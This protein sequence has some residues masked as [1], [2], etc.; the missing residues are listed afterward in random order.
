MTQLNA[1][2]GYSSIAKY[3]RP[4]PEIDED[5]WQIAESWL[6]KE[7]GP[8]MRDSAILPY[9]IVLAHIDKTTS[10]GYP[11]NRAHSTKS[12]V[13]KN[14]PF[15]QEEVQLLFDKLATDSPIYSFWTCAQK[16]ELRVKSKLA[17]DPPRHRTF[18]ASSLDFTINSNRMCLDQNNKFYRANTKTA[19]F[20]GGSKFRKG[21]DSAYRK[22][23][24]HPNGFA[25]D[26][27]DYDACVHRRALWS[28]A[29]FR[30][31]ML[32]VEDRTP[33]NWIRMKNVYQ[34]IINSM[35]VLEDGTVVFK[36]TG[37]PS[38]SANTVVD[39]TL[40]LY[41]DLAYAWV[42][43][44][45]KNVDLRRTWELEHKEDLTEAE[46]DELNAS[47]KTVLSYSHFKSNVELLLY[48]D[49]NTF[50]VS[51]DCIS[52]FNA[53]NIIEVW[54]TIGI[55]TKTDCLD[56]R[57][58][59]EL[60]FLSQRVLKFK[61]T[62][63]PYPDPDS[64]INSLYHKTNSDDNRWHLLRAFALRNECWAHKPTRQL[65]QGYIDW[66]WQTRGETLNGILSILGTNAKVT[67]ENI[68]SV[69]MTD[70]EL[71]RLYMGYEVR[72]GNSTDGPQ[73]VSCPPCPFHDQDAT[74]PLPCAQSLFSCPPVSFC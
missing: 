16:H 17:E 35:I 66:M 24:R 20:V 40:V 43:L 32:R 69:Y 63:L 68:C 39:N 48:G 25:L 36:D 73:N 27:T 62:W 12:D 23:A 50:T 72:P 41:M 61:G 33:E 14:R 71:E 51:D 54:A 57:P 18:T 34:Q 6:E 28:I 58:F 52:W 22:L 55:R 37:N 59:H 1:R 30:F 9:D 56:P 64:I 44:Y 3:A 49:D 26:E 2:S 42:K 45:T 38:G 8:H 5:A 4:Q 31:K 70:D 10:P 47:M 19:S 11:F 13:I 7:F 65:L 15:F 60:D 29:R 53:R 67:M 74:C 46:W 21:F